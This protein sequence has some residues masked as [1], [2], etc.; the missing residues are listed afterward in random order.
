MLS[1]ATQTGL[2]FCPESAV[3][4]SSEPHSPQ[5]RS[6]LGESSLVPAPQ[7]DVAQLGALHGA[8]LTCSGGLLP[9][10]PASPAH[11]A[12]Q[13]HQ[14]DGSRPSLA[15][16]PQNLAISQWKKHPG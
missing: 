12:A 3:T 10:P 11:P 14:G 1:C 4:S 15:W 8:T 16:V 9:S 5:E 7:A 13:P 6:A 2:S